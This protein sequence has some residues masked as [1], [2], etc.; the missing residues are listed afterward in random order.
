MDTTGYELDQD[1][2]DSFER[3]LKIENAATGIALS[4]VK[5]SNMNS[6]SKQQQSNSSDNGRRGRNKRNSRK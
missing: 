2:S 6:D 5:L 3:R 4:T 1:S